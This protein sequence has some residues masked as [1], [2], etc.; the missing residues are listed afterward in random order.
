MKE[1][2][3]AINHIAH[4][5]RSLL[6]GQFLLFLQYQRHVVLSLL[7][8]ALEGMRT[9]KNSTDA[10]LKPNDVA[11]PLILSFE[12]SLMTTLLLQEAVA[13][14][15]VRQDEVVHVIIKRLEID[16]SQSVQGAALV[17]GNHVL[18]VDEGILQ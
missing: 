16:M 18:Y 7:G 2:R 11:Y 5:L 12:F 17:R 6:R 1:V 8:Y 15:K 3:H 4:H 14:V 9:T 13:V 10:C